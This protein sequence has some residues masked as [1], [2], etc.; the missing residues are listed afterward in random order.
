MRKVPSIKLLAF[1]A[2][3]FFTPLIFVGNTNELFEFPKTFFIYIFGSTLIFVFLLTHIL[4]PK[5]LTMPSPLIVVWLIVNVVSTLFSSHFYTSIWGYYT[6]FNGG[7]VSVLILFGVYFVAVNVLTRENIENLGSVLL[8]TLIPIGVYAVVQHFNIQRVYSTFG[9]PNWVAAYV[10][11]LLPLCLYVSL[12]ATRLDQVLFWF[13]V[14]V[15][16]FSTLWFTYS[17]SGLLGLV[18]G[19]AA[20]CVL[21]RTEIVKKANLAKVSMLVLVCGI[22]AVTNLGFFENR[23]TDFFTDA[24][25]FISYQVVVF[26]QSD[27]NYNVSDAGFI[28]KGIWQG[29]LKLIVSSPKIFLVGTGPETFPYDFQKF[30]VPELNYS[31]EW[32]FILNKPH[33]YYLE[34]FSQLGVLGLVSYMLLIFWAIRARSIVTTP[35]IIALATTNIFGWPTAATALLFWMLL[36]FLEMQHQ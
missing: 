23:V 32:D 15:L 11:M 28:R 8:F 17:L 22:T 36:A 24:K 29:T 7:L 31:S 18:T 5:P 30:R 26:A 10:T 35:A 9:Q 33:N 1:I 6:R 25:R 21:A 14:F 4:N 2:F 20:I 12:K 3:L 27:S 13:F 34:V 16:G 19:L